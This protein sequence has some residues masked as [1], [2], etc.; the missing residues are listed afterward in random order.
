MPTQFLLA[1]HLYINQT[2]YFMQMMN[3]YGKSQI[4]RENWKEFHLLPFTKIPRLKDDTRGTISFILG[5]GKQKKMI[6]YD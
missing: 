3:V 4:P 1:T 2:K 6:D 5:K